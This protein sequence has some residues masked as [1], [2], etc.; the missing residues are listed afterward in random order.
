MYKVMLLCLCGRQVF[1]HPPSSSRS[2][3]PPSHVGVI[4][5]YDGAHGAFLA[6]IDAASVT[7]VRTA[8]ASAI[9]TRALAVDRPRLTLALVGAGVQ[10]K[11]HLASIRCVRDIGFVRIWSR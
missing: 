8:A 11:A 9:A 3:P 7:A 10:A 5:L 4:L 1:T 6:T 2:H